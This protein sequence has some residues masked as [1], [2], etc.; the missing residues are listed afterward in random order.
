MFRFATGSGVVTAER[1]LRFRNLGSFTDQKWRQ[2]SNTSLPVCKFNVLIGS[3][4][5]P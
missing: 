5:I 2:N 3:D 1:H 4:V